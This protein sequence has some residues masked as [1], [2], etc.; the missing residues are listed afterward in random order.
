MSAPSKIDQHDVEERVYRAIA[1]QFD[2][3]HSEIKP[4]WKLVDDLG[5]DSYALVALLLHLEDV[6]QTKMQDVPD[7]SINTVED[8]VQ[9]VRLHLT[10]AAGEQAY[11][12]P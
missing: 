12:E 10:G 4:G 6:F 7:T 11:T 5:A 9:Y 2:V 8:V 3:T 1:M